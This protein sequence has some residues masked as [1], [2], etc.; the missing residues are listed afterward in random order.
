MSPQKTSRAQTLSHL[1]FWLTLFVTLAAVFAPSNLFY[2]FDQFNWAVR[3]LRIDYLLPK[4]YLSD[5]ILL[6]IF[7]AGFCTVSLKNFAKYWLEKILIVLGI[8]LLTRQ[9]FTEFPTAAVM[10]FLR[11]SLFGAAAYIVSKNWSRLRLN[12]VWFG[13][14]VSNVLEGFLSLWQFFM[15]QSL[16]SYRTLFGEPNLSQSFGLAQE[17]FG[18]WGE[19]IL[20]YGTTAHPNIL[21]AWLVSSWLLLMVWSSK[22]TFA[23]PLKMLVLL[24]SGAAAL[25][26][27]F[28]TQSITALGLLLH[29]IGYLMV[30]WIFPQFS[31]NPRFL[32]ISFIGLVLAIAA[33]PWLTQW[34]LTLL[35]KNFTEQP[36]V[37][38]RIFLHTAGQ[39][40]LYQNPVWGVGLNQFTADLE[41]TSQFREPVRFDQPVHH[42]MWLWIIETGLL[43][44]GLLI[45]AL[46]RT[47]RN[48]PPQLI[49]LIV[50][51]WLLFPSLVW[52][53]YLFTQPTG[54]FILWFWWVSSRAGD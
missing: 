25:W 54:L 30:K 4:I 15:Q 10:Q 37:T 43:G 41:A 12:W 2:G 8:V 50:M 5:L 17:S 18:S 24:I 49:I 44:L 32:K 52:D 47:L 9:F 42:V 33:S 46:W 39:T 6:G 53:H 51:L 16:G 26:G 1:S 31:V 28:A 20:P 3:G 21:A 23:K 7:L 34:S 19:K 48:N 29:G 27:V 14:V 11:L 22:I 35:P 13:L 38:R 36:S 45:L 40:M